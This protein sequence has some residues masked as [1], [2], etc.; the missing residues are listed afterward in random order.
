MKKLII[1]IFLAIFT[2]AGCSTLETSV[3]RNTER[4][5]RLIYQVPFVYCWNDP[6]NPVPMVYRGRPES[7]P[8]YSTNSK[9]VVN[10]QTYFV[11]VDSSK[12][13]RVRGL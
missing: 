3:D 6:Y 8:F 10:Y 5:I 4:Q 11:N 7:S 1:V 13:V 9:C 2:I 12:L